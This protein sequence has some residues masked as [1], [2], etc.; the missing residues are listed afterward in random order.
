MAQ[1]HW[2]QGMSYFR[3]SPSGSKE[4]GGFI[5]HWS[6]VAPRGCRFPGTSSCPHTQAKWVSAT[7]DP[8]SGAGSW[9]ESRRGPTAHR[10][11]KGTREVWGEHEQQLLQHPKVTGCWELAHVKQTPN[12]L[13]RLQGETTSRHT[14]FSCPWISPYSPGR[15]ACHKNRDCRL[16]THSA[17]V[18]TAFHDGPALQW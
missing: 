17:R 14:R 6:R 1:S 3:G 16:R 7:C 12:R 4:L 8:S 9:R 18:L 15:K 13:P 5:S 2:G 10:H 11:G